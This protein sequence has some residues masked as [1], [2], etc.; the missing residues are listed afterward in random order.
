MKEV[1]GKL[2][3]NVDVTSDFLR[4]ESAY[5]ELFKWL[6]ERAEVSQEDLLKHLGLKKTKTED[7]VIIRISKFQENPKPSG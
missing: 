4:D 2:Q 3:F 5:V 6:N 1:D 7:T